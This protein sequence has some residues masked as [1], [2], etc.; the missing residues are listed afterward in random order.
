MKNI[1]NMNTCIKSITDSNV[2]PENN[3]FQL[4]VQQHKVEKT[5]NAHNFHEITIT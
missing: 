4:N 5:I 2:Y 3:Q 1:K